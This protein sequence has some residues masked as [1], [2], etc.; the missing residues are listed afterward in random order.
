MSQDLKID[1][2]HIT[3]I[4][5][6]GSIVLDAKNGKVVSAQWRVP[7]APR[8]FEA[9]V[10][11][12]SYNELPHITSRIC[13]ICSISHTLTSLK[14][15]ENAMG[16]DISD[17]TLLLRKLAHHAET[18]QSHILH[19]GYLIA[20]DL[21]GVGSVFPLVNTHKDAVVKIVK[22]HRL[23][24]EMSDLLCGRTTHPVSMAV[25]GFTKI[26]TEKE[27]T[28]V[29]ARL[30]GAV[31]PA[32]EVIGIVLANA[33]KLP[34]FTRETEYIGLTSDEEYALY[35]GVIGSTD[36]GR[37]KLED[38][39]S[40]TNEFVVPHSTAKWTKHN[41]DSYMVGA[42]ARYNLNSRKLTPL[43]KEVAGKFGLKAP[44]FNPFMNN[45]AQLVEF[46][47]VLEDSIQII[48]E[49]LD[50][51]LKEEKVEVKVKAGRGIGAIEAPRGVLFHDYTIDE[52]GKCV[53]ANCIIPTNQNHG[54]I[55]KDIEALAPTLLDKSKSEIELNLEMLVRAYDPCVSCST[56]YLKVKF[57]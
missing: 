36:T 3:R 44:C 20:P 12:R 48:D 10:V 51:G 45:V 13:G 16:V 11:G 17:Q 35:D 30:Q 34:G 9:M 26:P 2:E 23:G 33:G 32:N 54:N 38:Y 46:A 27:L 8:F 6:H 4:E 41:R 40:I 19:V 56:H 43:A 49:L 7:E 15:V 21:F 57:V 1:L 53:K 31:K 37:H 47:Y 25:G 18:I 5:G 14:A 24:N 55:Q 50:D 52:R 28:E 22:L 39:L 29:K 42:L